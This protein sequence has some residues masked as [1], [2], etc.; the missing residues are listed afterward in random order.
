MELKYDFKHYHKNVMD[1][2][3]LNIDGNKKICNDFNCLICITHKYRNFED[4][5]YI[6]KDT[7]RNKQ[8]D[9]FEKQYNEKRDVINYDAGKLLLFYKDE[10]LNKYL[11]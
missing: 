1:D 6:V 8:F 7:E 11:K 5:E 10:Y 3:K 2:Y 9:L 4:I